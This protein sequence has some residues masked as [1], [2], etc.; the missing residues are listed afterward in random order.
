MAYSKEWKANYEQVKYAVGLGENT[1][2]L[3]YKEAIL[4]GEYADKITDGTLSLSKAV[5]LAHAGIKK[6]Y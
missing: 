4:I 6:L 5:L 1:R 2:P 3:Y